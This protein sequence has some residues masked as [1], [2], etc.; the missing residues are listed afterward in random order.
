MRPIR[1]S[2]NVLR[3]RRWKIILLAC[4]ALGL[5]IAAAWLHAI[6]NPI[7]VALL[8]AY[9]AEP[10]IA[11]MNAHH[12]RRTLAVALVY[13]VA[14]AIMGLSVLTLG[15]K[16]V[17]Q[18]KGLYRYMSAAAQKYGSRMFLDPLAQAQSALPG[19]GLETDLPPIEA[20]PPEETPEAPAEPGP[21]GATPESTD[22]PESSNLGA[23]YL[24]RARDYMSE[25][26]GRIAGRIGVLLAATI[27]QVGKG[28]KGAAAFAFDTVLTLV[29]GF[30]FML[31]FQNMRAAI[32]RY[33]P[34]ANREVTVRIL[35]RIDEATSAFFRGRL[36]ICFVAGIV[37][38]IGL[39]LSG[40]AYWLLIGLAA[41]ILGFIPIIGVLVTLIPACAFALLT[42]HPLGSLVGV[43]VTFAIVQ[44]IVEPLVGTVIL[45]REVKLHPAIIILALL[46]GGSLFGMF[47]LIL[48][49]PMAATLKILNQEFVIPSLEDLAHPD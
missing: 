46:V 33:I 4:V 47:G 16:F 43:L 32:R 7:L 1:K 26:A 6:F 48:S 40:I 38:S 24:Q 11:W 15:P 27:Q 44:W 36:L 31:H 30:F 39:W 29:F 19:T 49:V 8:L 2:R 12:V 41:G 18:G 23:A 20:P 21:G 45:S 28:I 34:A 42:T 5:F 14:F 10:L 3:S 13:I 17:R 37:C 22:E 9:V 35:R 25:N